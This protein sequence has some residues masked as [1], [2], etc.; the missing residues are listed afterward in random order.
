MVLCITVRLLL[1]LCVPAW[2]EL[3]AERSFMCLCL[4]YI[5]YVL[6]TEAFSRILFLDNLFLWC[7]ERT[8]VNQTSLGKAKPPTADQTL[9]YTSFFVLILPL[10]V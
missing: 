9:L 7:S 8:L 6:P 10:N 1:V 4:P 2:L 3:E 5:S